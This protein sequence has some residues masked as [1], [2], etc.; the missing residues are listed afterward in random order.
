MAMLP[1]STSGAQTESLLTRVARYIG[2]AFS[3]GTPAPKETGPDSFVRGQPFSIAAQRR[4]DLQNSGRTAGRST[5]APS[6]D[7]QLVAYLNHISTTGNPS[8]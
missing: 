8:V 5:P 4:L 1:T 3:P 2:E 7:A 6:Q